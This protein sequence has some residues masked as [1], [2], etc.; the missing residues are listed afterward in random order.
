MISRAQDSFTFY[1]RATMSPLTISWMWFQPR[2]HITNVFKRPSIWHLGFADTRA[3]RHALNLFVHWHR[4]CPQSQVL[5]VIWKLFLIRTQGGAIIAQSDGW[6]VGWNVRL[7]RPPLWFKKELFLEG[8]Q[9]VIE[10][11][12][13]REKCDGTENVGDSDAWL[14][15]L[16]CTDSGAALWVVMPDFIVPRLKGSPLGELHYSSPALSDKA[17][18]RTK[19]TSAEPGRTPTGGLVSLKM[20]CDRKLAKTDSPAS[21]CPPMRMMTYTFLKALLILHNHQKSICSI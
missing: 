19:T 17:A 1:L 16:L 13:T 8:R 11:F 10:V 4:C 15:R 7:P 18:R 9:A 12:T 5:C 3:T 2:L 14:N 21:K 6:A 20:H